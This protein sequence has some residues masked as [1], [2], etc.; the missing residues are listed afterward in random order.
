LVVI[1]LFRHVRHRV[2]MQNQAHDHA[3]RNSTGAATSG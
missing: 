2:Q 3:Q 1:Y